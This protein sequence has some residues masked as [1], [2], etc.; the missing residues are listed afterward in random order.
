MWRIIVPFLQF[1]VDCVLVLA[2]FA[3]VSAVICWIWE[4]ASLRRH[5]RREPF[6]M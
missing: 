5:R 2:A 3:I 6:M 4:T 1:A